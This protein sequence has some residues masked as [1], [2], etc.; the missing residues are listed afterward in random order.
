MELLEVLSEGRNIRNPIPVEIYGSPKGILSKRFL[1]AGEQNLEY[2]AVILE[3]DLGL[4]RMDV[5]ID[6]ARV[7]LHVYEI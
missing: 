3:L 5:H 6:R 7:D 4:G 2:D 1:D